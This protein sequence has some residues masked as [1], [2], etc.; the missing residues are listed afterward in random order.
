[1]KTFC[2]LFIIHYALLILNCFPQQPGWEIIPSG[3]NN[4][5]NSV[6]FYD[7]EIGF[8]CGDSG[9]VIKSIDSGKTW[10]AIS[11]PVTY[12]L[13]DL[14]VFNDSTL[15]VVGD[16]GTMLFSFDGGVNWYGSSSFLT[17]EDYLSQLRFRKH[18][19]DE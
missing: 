13:N 10:Q 9:T 14:F 3:T 4:P 1:M 6:F 5:L 18:Y 11:T 7:Y 19:N 12:N 17:S 16:F 15:C 2:L 8:A